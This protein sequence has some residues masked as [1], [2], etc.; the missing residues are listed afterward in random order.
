MRIF[1]GPNSWISLYVVLLTFRPISQ[2]LA[3]KRR[4]RHTVCNVHCVSKQRPPY[5]V[6]FYILNN[7]VKNG[8]SLIN[9]TSENRKLVHHAGILSPWNVKVALFL[10]H[11]SYYYNID[12]LF[13]RYMTKYISISPLTIVCSVC[14]VQ[15]TEVIIV[16]SS[17]KWLALTRAGWCVVCVVDYLSS[18]I[19][20]F[21]V[22]QGSAVTL[23]RWGG[24]V[25]NFMM[26]VKFHQNIV[27]Q[28]LLKSIQP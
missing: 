25:Y 1:R 23:F 17:N 13:H 27:Y 12:V 15:L 19:S 20:Y 7:L 8:T 18:S 10:V 9:F 11:N 22:S 4:I 14:Y 21:C 6:P 3:S 28:K 24:R 2:G 16:S 5:W 26:Y